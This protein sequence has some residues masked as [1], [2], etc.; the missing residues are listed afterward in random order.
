SGHFEFQVKGLRGTERWLETH[1]TALRDDE[2][3]IIAHLGVTRD[4]TDKKRFDQLIWQKA[5]FDQLT[6][7]PNRNMFQ[8]RLRHELKLA[9]RS[10]NHLAVLFIDLDHFKEVNDTL[11]H[12][13]GDLLLVEVAQRITGCV[14]ESDTVARLGGDEFMVILPGF[15]GNAVLSGIADKIIQQLSAPFYLSEALA[16][17]HVTASIG[18]TLYPD[19]G[20][21]ADQLMRNVDQAMYVA[22]AQGRNCFA[23]FTPVL[24]EQTEYRLNLLQDLRHALAGQQFSLC[25][26][27]IV[28]LSS[29]RVVKLEA[30][31]R[32]QHPL[33][34]AVSP[35][36]F[37]PLAEE[38]GL[39]IEIGHWVVLEC[40]RWAQRWVQAVA[41]DV[42]IGVNV[43]PVQL[44][45]SSGRVDLLFQALH[46]AGLEPRHL[47][48]EIT[49]GLLLHAS[50]SIQSVLDRL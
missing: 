18:I 47:A 46:E 34:G 23:W 42:Q 44:Q 33:R 10:G 12:H 37:I 9:A 17:T 2:N 45:N 4:I 36:E 40:I 35:A 16:E 11:G 27:P 1:G 13:A 15:P 32:W 38:S 6:G 26:Q 28:E 7:L 50:P 8:D 3:R 22:K 5:N 41:R 39:I 49:E 43:S 20:D 19:D 48:L 14:R 24:R 25:F 29:G 31:L 30:L 21:S